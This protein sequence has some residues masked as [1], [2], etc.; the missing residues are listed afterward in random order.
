MK[1][2][3][4]APD[5]SNIRIVYA[6]FSNAEDLGMILLTDRTRRFAKG[7]VLAG[8]ESADKLFARHFEEKINKYITLKGWTEPICFILYARIYESYG[9]MIVRYLRNQFR[10]CKLVAYY[11]DLVSR[12]KM[13][14]EKVKLLFDVC[15]TF[16]IHDAEAYGLQW[17]AEVYSA[18]ILK[19]AAFQKPNIKYDVVFVG[20][21][22]TRYRKILSLYEKLREA[23][24]NCDFHIVGVKPKDRA[25]VGEIGYDHMDYKELLRHVSSSRCIAEVVQ[26]F[27]GS[28]TTRYSEAMLFRKN[29][30]TN[31][32]YF[33]ETAHRSPNVIY[34]HNTADLNEMD[35]QKLRILPE[36]DVKPYVDLLSVRTMIKTVNRALGI[37]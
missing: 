16:D 30:L 15:M 32:A 33:E 25:Y 37:L 12:H 26:D 31:C 24:L 22:K 4:I 3:F 6:E 36:Y 21:A 27:G 29:L 19:D 1:Y 34:F 14:V 7:L 18:D 35:L 28:P 9:E 11:G 2:V 17:C 20:S 23:G 13:A 10:D 5:A 8:F